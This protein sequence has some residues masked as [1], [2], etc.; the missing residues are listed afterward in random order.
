MKDQSLNEQAGKKET[1]APAQVLPDAANQEQGKAPEFPQIRLVPADGSD[2]P[3]LSNY[4]TVQVAPAMVYLDF[5]FIEPG[6][7]AALQATV[8]TNGTL[9][10]RINGRLATRV[11][12]SMDVLQ[13]LHTQLGA[14]IEGVTSAAQQ[15]LAAYS[16]AQKQKQH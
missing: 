1:S 3:V 8:R 12:L 11:A 9:P 2:Q 6:L 14:V 15:Q 13:A 7:I 5:G 4:A 16:E 10:E